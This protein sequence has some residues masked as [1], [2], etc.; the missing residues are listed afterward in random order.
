MEGIQSKESQ[1]NNL[2]AQ[3]E[4]SILRI[5]EK[6]DLVGYL[7]K[8]SNEIEIALLGA[9]IPIEVLPLTVYFASNGVGKPRIVAFDKEESGRKFADSYFNSEDVRLEYR[10]GE[11]VDLASLD[12]LGVRSYDMV[13]VRKP[14][15][16]NS[17]HKWEKIFENGFSH[18][19]PGGIFLATTDL[20]ADF[21]LDQLRKG[22][23]VV[24]EYTI[25]Q[26]D[27]IAPFFTEADLFVAKKA[28]K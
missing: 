22:G 24:K 3:S 8:N 17:K 26:P 5:L 10:A 16:H 12:T 25:P 19:K 18:L 7:P 4:S 1:S 9:G 20:Y 21:V 13:I 28:V 6:I 23:Q 2:V 27:R 11:D 15:V 14:D